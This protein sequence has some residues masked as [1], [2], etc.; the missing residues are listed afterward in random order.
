MGRDRLASSVA[1]RNDIVVGAV[2]LPRDTNDFFSC[3]CGRCKLFAASSNALR[4]AIVSGRD[5]NLTCYAFDADAAASLFRL[6]GRINVRANISAISVVFRSTIDVRSLHA[7]A[8]R[9]G[10]FG[11]CRFVSY[12]GSNWEFAAYQA[13]IET[14]EPNHE[15][16]IVVNDTA[17][18]NYPFL[19][20]DLVRFLRQ[21]DLVKGSAK[22]AIIG[23]VETAGAIF[24]FNGV[25]F[26]RWI[27]S[28]LFYINRA[29]LDSLN[30]SV[31]ERHVFDAPSCRDGQLAV[32]V[33]MS[34]EL[35]RYLL[36]WMD[37]SSGKN[38]WLAHARRPQVDNVVRRGKLGS[39][40]LEKHLSARLIAAQAEVISYEPEGNP[41]WHALAVRLFFKRR[42]LRQLFYR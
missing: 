8:H 6:I 3:S 15:G 35:E 29:A 37:P 34:N 7:M 12:D 21:I 5:V 16:V 24:S 11:S 9:E 39:I 31:F 22:P 28:N 40:L 23:K 14:L 20:G 42:R 19:H 30:G 38:G 26:D 33:P 2:W 18:R 4:N 10:I 32:G 25:E 13:G 41:L 1:S 27:R 36:R 17:G